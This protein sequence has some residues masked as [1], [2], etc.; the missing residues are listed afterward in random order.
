MVTGGIE[1]R[2]V[3]TGGIEVRVVV[4]GGIEVC[5]GHWWD[6]GVWWSLVG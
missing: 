3:V 2:V 5:G 6:R 4:T 1:V